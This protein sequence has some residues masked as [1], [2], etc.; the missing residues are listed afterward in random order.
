VSWDAHLI[1]GDEEI[2][3]ENY[4]HNTNRMIERALGDAIVSTSESWW[5]KLNSESPL[6]RWSWWKMLDGRSGADGAELLRA[7]LEK[8]DAEP[9]VFRAMNPRGGWGSFDGLCGVLRRM[10]DAGDEH[11]NGKWEVNG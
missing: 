11:P 9:G 6:G 1:E 8:F 2:V 10:A 3:W 5:W 7:I 4:T